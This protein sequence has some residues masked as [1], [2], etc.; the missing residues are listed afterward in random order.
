M[1]NCA[2]HGVFWRKVPARKPVATRRRA[3]RAAPAGGPAPR[4]EALP[5]ADECG[6]GRFEC[7]ECG[8]G[9]TSNTAHR[10]LAQYCNE[11]DARNSAAAS[12]LGDGDYCVVAP[13]GR[14]DADEPAGTF[15][16][17][18][19]REGGGGGGGATY[20]E[21]TPAVADT[22]IVVE[23]REGDAAAAAA[24]KAAPK[25]L[26]LRAHHCSGC[27]TGRCKRPP[28]VSKTHVSTGSTA[29]SLSTKTW[30]TGG[31]SAYTCGSI[32]SKY[33]PADLVLID[34]LL[35]RG[36]CDALIAA[37]EAETFGSTG[38]PRQYRGNLR[39]ITTD[40]SLADALWARLRPLVPATVTHKGATWD[41]YGCNERLRVAR[42]ETGDLFASHLDADYRR[43]DGSMFTVNI[44]L[45]DV[46]DGGRT[47][48]EGGERGRERL[49]NLAVAPAAGRA[50]VFAQPSAGRYL[51]HDGEPLGSG[52]KY[53]LRTDV[54]YRRRGGEPAARSDDE[55]A[56]L[57]GL[58]PGA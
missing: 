22:K 16:Y 13:A 8:H 26:G 55:V 14:A 57:Y 21:P 58:A 5:V 47:R 32:N 20:Y 17:D 15:Y 44:Y 42:Y 28:P 9:W 2:R 39:L 45:N 31:S 56:R 12:G 6:R 25:R 53:L 35:A 7:Q 19:A 10:S 24:P 3:A 49:V 52:R 46:V 11:C 18:P 38:F 27:A 4:L 37:A 50:V 1:F 34:G 54:M 33:D 30:S 29:T 40:A 48:F 36:E 43:G 23:P 51:Y 41:A